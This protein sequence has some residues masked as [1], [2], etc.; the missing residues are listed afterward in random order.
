MAGQTVSAPDGRK[1]EVCVWSDPE[2]APVFWRGDTSVPV[3]HGEWLVRRLPAAELIT[4]DGGQFGP[5]HEPELGLLTWVGH[6]TP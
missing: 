4:V 3:A 1:L 5:R 2:G 6:G